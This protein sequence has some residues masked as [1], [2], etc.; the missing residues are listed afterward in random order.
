MSKNYKF[1][2]LGT[3]EEFIC[4][5]NSLRRSR[6]FYYGEYMIK[7]TENEIRF[8]IERGGHSGGYWYIPTITENEDK[9]ELY[10]EICYIGPED[11]RSKGRK[12]AD[13]LFY[14]LLF[15]IIVVFVLYG[16]IE[17]GIRK[18]FKLSKP[19]T[20][21]DKLFDLMQNLGCKKID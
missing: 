21:E 16:F 18:I 11:N 12:I 20:T 17:M 8:G 6:P 3:K 7:I 1:E 4:A 15:P 2:F 19:K 13:A 10:G 14:I 9:T 5:I